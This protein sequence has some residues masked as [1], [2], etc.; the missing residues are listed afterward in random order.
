MSLQG[1]VGKEHGYEITYWH[2]DGR[3]I[4]FVCMN[5]EIAVSSTG[6]GNS[7]GLKADVLPVTL[8]FAGKINGVRDERTGK[9]L[10]GGTEFKF[11]WPMNEAIVISFEGAPPRP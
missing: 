3:T 4:L 10:G 2:K 5:P 9:D 1:G 11:D 6:G 8:A 7:V